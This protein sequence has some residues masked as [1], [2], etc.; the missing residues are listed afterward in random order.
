MSDYLPPIR[1]S[2]ALVLSDGAL[3]PHSVAIAQGRFSDGDYPA[4]DLTG[5]YVLPG[6]IDLH[7]DAFERHITPRPSAPFPVLSGLHGVDREAAA[8]G[9]TTA[10]LAQS[11]SWEGGMRGPDFAERVMAALA[12]Y[13][14][15]A[16]TDLRIQI[17][18]ETHEHEHTDRLIAAIE[19]WGI[20]Y[21]I[22]NNHLGEAIKQARADPAA[23]AAWA[24]KSGRT[25]AEFMAVVDAASCRGGEVP[26]RLARLAEAFDRLGVR[27]G[28]HDDPDPETRET[29]AMIGARICEFPL[30]SQTATVAKAVGSPVLM[31]APN[32][33][34]GTSQAGNVAAEHLIRSGSCTA[35]VSD[36][37]Y[38]ALAQAAFRLADQGIRPL[39]QAW[40]MISEQPAAIMG[41]ADRGVIKMNRRADLVIIN[42][43]TRAIE[44]TIC[45]GRVSYLSGAAALRFLRTSDALRV[46][47]E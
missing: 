28:S 11:W 27:Y 43:A 36:Y 33:V 4:V 35:I 8:N 38:P 26:R 20:D 14:S 9:I 22:F 30:N 17:R 41:L 5:Y 23:L 45:G 29:F 24:S 34:R 10:W 19:R 37:H 3:A 12:E 46:A 18:C 32:V 39:A 25:A 6:I 31:G 2:G 16:L 40:A 13:K 15:N 1:L 44:A 7:G 47:A 21:V 42:Q